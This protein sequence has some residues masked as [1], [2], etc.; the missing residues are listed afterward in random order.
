MNILI[1]VILNEGVIGGCTNLCGHLNSTAARDACDL[2]CGT[3]GIKA[4]IKA[5]DNTDLDTIY[6]CEILHL[7]QAGADDAHID[8]LDIQFNPAKVAIED[9]QVGM[10]GVDIEG[11]LPLMSPRRQE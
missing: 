5:L 7:C 10:D 11:V 1:N 4:F 2:V 9:I 6:F 8:L 3:V